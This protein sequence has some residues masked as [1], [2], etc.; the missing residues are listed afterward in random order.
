LSHLRKNCVWRSISDPGIVIFESDSMETKIPKRQPGSHPL[1]WGPAGPKRELGF[2]RNPR[3]YLGIL[4]GDFFGKYKL[5]KVSN[6]LLLMHGK[7]SG[8][9]IHEGVLE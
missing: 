4:P 9:N 7:I 1:C 3:Q 6:D 2:P 8:Q 5:I